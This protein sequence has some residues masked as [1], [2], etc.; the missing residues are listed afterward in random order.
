MERDPGT[1]IEDAFATAN[2]LNQYS[3][4]IL[5]ALRDSSI[6]L[7][8]SNLTQTLDARAVLCEGRYSP[9]EIDTPFL[10]QDCFA[11]RRIFLKECGQ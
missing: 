2:G 3:T 5:E 10:I 4:L 6:K 1:L 11:A 9:D 8:G 7:V